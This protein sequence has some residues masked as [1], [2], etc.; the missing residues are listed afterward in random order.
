VGEGD[1]AKLPEKI[2]RI[3]NCQRMRIEN[4]LR[5]RIG[6]NEINFGDLWQSCQF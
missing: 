2:A 6:L 4:L 1:W 3:D 5:K